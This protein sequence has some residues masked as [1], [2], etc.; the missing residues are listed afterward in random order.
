MAE[1]LIRIAT[2]RL[3][4]Q[5]VIG[6]LRCGETVAIGEDGHA[7]SAAERDNPDWTIVAIPG[8][9]AERLARLL[10]R[11]T[12]E[13]K[14]LIASGVW[15]GELVQ[16]RRRAWRLD[17]EALAALLADA[18]ASGAFLAN[19]TWAAAFAQGLVVRWD[20]PT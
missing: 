14:A 17:P 11:Y 7:W 3:G 8:I 6:R 19:P 4:G 15:N 5:E 2:A 20:A 12:D 13:E 9:P 16:E 18:E 1:V 10:D